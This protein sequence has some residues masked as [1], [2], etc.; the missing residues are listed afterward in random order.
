MTNLEEFE[1][2]SEAYYQEVSH[3]WTEVT[4]QKPPGPTMC[5]GET[6]APHQPPLSS[7]G[8]LWVGNVFGCLESQS[9]AVAITW[10]STYY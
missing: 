10:I 8:A 6:D 4:G 3:Y 1:I 7:T 9:L 5:S 2:Q